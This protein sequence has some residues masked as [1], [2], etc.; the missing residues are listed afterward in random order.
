V[1]VL[2]HDQSFLKRLYDRL[3]AQNLEHK[4]LHLSRIGQSNTVITEWD[5]EEA[6]QAQYRAD[7][8]AL[9]NFYNGID[10]KPRDVV[11]KIRP[12]LESFCRFICP[13]Q[14]DDDDTLGVI[15]GKISAA[16]PGHGLA[17]VYDDLDAVNLYTRRYHHGD[18]P[19]SAASEPIYDTELQGFVGKTLSIVGYY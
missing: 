15:C 8:K 1:I 4:C 18:S 11:N 7:L 17:N 14:F 12:V 19:L 10:G 3:R 16:G 13:T 2:S 6:T 5:I 9:A